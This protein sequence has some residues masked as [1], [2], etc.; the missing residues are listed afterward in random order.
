MRARRRELVALATVV[1]S[2][3]AGVSC[4]DIGLAA[5]VDNGG[6]CTNNSACVA[7]T[8]SNTLSLSAATTSIPVGG[9]VAIT[10]MY[11]GQLLISNSL[12]LQATVSDSTVLSGSAF[13]ASGLSVGGATIT[14]TYQG[15]SASIS[16]VVV[17]QD[18]LSGIMHLITSPST[19][20]WQ[21]FPGAM[22]VVPGAAVEFGIGNGAVQHN[23]VFDSVP[24]APQNIPAGASGF[25]TVS[26]FETVGSFPFHCSI[27]GEAGVINVVSP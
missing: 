20:A 18:G 4:K 10:P 19:G 9:G 16:F 23:V 8:P 26:T 13:A 7:T 5:P 27:H 3:L 17:P 1:V 12:A 2:S 24:G 15:A 6:A 22:H 11:N 14:A 21:W 25:A